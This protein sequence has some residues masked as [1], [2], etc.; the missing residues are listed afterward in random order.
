MT[1]ID[2]TTKLTKIFSK[3]GYDY[4]GH[5]GSGS[6]S[7]VYLCNCPKYNNKFA[8]K[9]ILK[10]KFVPHEYD[11]LISLENPHIIKLYLTFE[12]EDSIFLVMEYCP[13]GS[14]RKNGNLDCDK[15]V[16]YAKQILE[17]LAFCHSKM[18]AHRDIKPDNIFLDQYDHIKLGD[19]GLSKQFEQNVKSAEKCG[20]LMFSAPEILLKNSICPFQSDIWALGITFF[21]MATGKYPFPNDNRNDLKTAIMM[22]QLDYSHVNMHPKI[23]SLIQKMT[24]RNPNLRLTTDQLLQLPIFK[25]ANKR[26]ISKAISMFSYQKNS[27][28]KSSSP[29]FLI[30]DKNVKA[31]TLDQQDSSYPNGE[32]KRMKLH[33]ISTASHFSNVR[34]IRRQHSFFS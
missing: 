28:I 22:G 9:Q 24:T 14:F 33:A 32:N 6:F 2:E 4:V 1:Q 5:I 15:F 31:F 34:Q 21:F 30:Q 12:E 8:I 3:H 11:S 7:S 17:A 10:E 26:Q 18:I 25:P 23:L 29:N 13:R 19:F 27:I 16:Y 20:S